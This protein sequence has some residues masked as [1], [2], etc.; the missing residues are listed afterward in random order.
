MELPSP[1]ARLVPSLVLNAVVTFENPHAPK[2]DRGTGP[3]V[4]FVRSGIAAHWK[5]SAY[6]NILELAEACDAPV[7]W[8]C[9]T[10]VAIAVRAAWSPGKSFTNQSRSTNLPMATFSSAAHSRCGTWL[11][12][13]DSGGGFNATN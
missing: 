7:R 4:S 6:Q 2:D 9:R 1:V 3:L 11:S 12:I 5:P 8:S 10:G 13:C